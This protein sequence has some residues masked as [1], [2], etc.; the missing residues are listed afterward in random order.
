MK[1]HAMFSEDTIEAPALKLPAELLSEVGRRK[2][3]QS[4]YRVDG[5]KPS[6]LERLARM[7]GLG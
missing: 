4:D 7:L 5:W 1:D 3:Q 2:K 6:L